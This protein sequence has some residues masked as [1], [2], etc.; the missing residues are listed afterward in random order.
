MAMG[1]PEQVPGLVM[2]AM[3]GVGQ[4]TSDLSLRFPMFLSHRTLWA[5]VFP[6]VWALGRS[7]CTPVL[8]NHTEASEGS[9]PPAGVFGGL[10]P[11]AGT[12]KEGY[13]HLYC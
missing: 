11:R 13:R 1:W 12:F 6:Y 4:P 7:R 9:T 2:M 5:Y 3:G 8:P 10:G